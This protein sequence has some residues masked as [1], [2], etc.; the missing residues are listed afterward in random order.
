M[1]EIWNYLISLIPAFYTAASLT[2]GTY[3]IRNFDYDERSN[4][5]TNRS[6]LRSIIETTE[7]DLLAVQEIN[8]ISEFKQ[9]IEKN[10]Y[11]YK[12]EI[13]E[14]GGAN[15]QKLG[16]IYNSARLKILSF[17]ESSLAQKSKGSCYEGGRPVAIAEFEIIHTKQKFHAFSVHLKSGGQADSINMRQQQF[18]ALE[19]LVSSILKNSETKDFI[20]AGD[21]NT[22]TFK[23]KN[24]DYQSTVSLANLINAVNITSNLKCTSYWWG[25]T[26]DGIEEPSILDHVLIS[27]NLIK[28]QTTPKLGG[29]CEQQSCKESKYND[30]GKS[31]SHVSDHCPVSIKIQ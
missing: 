22:T 31:Y 2:V 29:H 21:M 28:V 11:N 15:N 25:N 30:L 6:E 23:E 24:V 10:F 20:I 27:K 16:F 1:S 14:C 5:K 3:N 12:T 19:K 26:D 7:A 9:F 4:T 17:R 18:V 13:S 8:N